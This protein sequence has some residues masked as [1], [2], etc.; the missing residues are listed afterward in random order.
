MKKS[1][2]LVTLTL[3]GCG[4]FHEGTF[5]NI[6]SCA[7]G[8]NTMLVSSMYGALGI[9]SKIRQVDAAAVCGPPVPVVLP[10]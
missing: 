8:D 5:D 9:T 6:A 1:L 4:T 3:A 2:I 7:K 10:K